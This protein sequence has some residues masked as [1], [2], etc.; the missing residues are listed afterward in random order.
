MSR[1]T[2]L[3]FVIGFALFNLVNVLGFVYALTM[4]EM[5]HGLVHLGLVVPGAFLVRHVARARVRSD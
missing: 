4:G 5:T 1:R 3:W 2:T